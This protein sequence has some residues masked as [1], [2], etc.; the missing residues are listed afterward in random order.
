LK[1][2]DYRKLAD[3]FGEDDARYIYQELVN[4]LLGNINI[5]SA[6]IEQ[7]VSLHNEG[8]TK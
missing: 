4:Y 7:R 2:V 5:K 3:A 1:S 8:E 6:I